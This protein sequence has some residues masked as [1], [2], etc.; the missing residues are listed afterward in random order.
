[1]ANGAAYPQA[2]VWDGHVAIKWLA[3]K[4]R[5]DDMGRVQSSRTRFDG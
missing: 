2:T 5:V 4:S 3:R 1:M